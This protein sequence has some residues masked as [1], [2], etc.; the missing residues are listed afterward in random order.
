MT[1]S[2]DFRKLDRVIHERGR[3]AIMS[4]LSGGTGKLPFTEIRD[5]LSMTDGNLSRHLATLEESGLVRLE[6]H[7]G[8]GRPL[9]EV[10]VTAD[11]RRAFASYVERLEAI[12]APARGA[13]RG[14]RGVE[15]PKPEPA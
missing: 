2:R 1:G 6:R 12:L 9:T 11:G 10:T 4:M 13:A 5:R 8:R 7:V 14:M 15:E 3:L